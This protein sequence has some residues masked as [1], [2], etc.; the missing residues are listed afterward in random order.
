MTGRQL[1]ESARRILSAAKKQ[2]EDSGF[3]RASIASIADEAGVASGTIYW[4]FHSKEELF[5]YLI[6][7]ENEAWLQRAQDVLNQDTNALQCLADIATASAASYSESKLLLAALRR[8]RQLIPPPL[9]QDVHSRL[10]NESISL[11]TQVIQDG[12]DEGSIRPVEA[13]KVAVVLFEA[14]HALFNQSTHSYEE[15]AKTLNEIMV[16]GLRNP[17]P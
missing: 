3:R 8:D 12:I 7:L 17:Q 6:D 16:L 11:L 2:F 15:L 10:A 9:L 14:G 4:H 13:E 1:N 5:L